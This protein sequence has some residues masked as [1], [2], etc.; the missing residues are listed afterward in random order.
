MNLFLALIT[1]FSLNISTAQDSTQL[2]ALDSLF[3]TLEENEKMMGTV[4]VFKNGKEVYQRLLGYRDI[5]ATGTLKPDTATQYRIGSISK[6]F[7]AVSWLTRQTQPRHQ[8]L[9]LLSANLYGRQYYHPRH[10]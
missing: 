7:T 5:R 1:V 6:M 8:T 10:A 2:H 3:N 4:S 9:C